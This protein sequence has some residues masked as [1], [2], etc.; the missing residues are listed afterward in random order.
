MYYKGV[1]EFLSDRAIVA[2]KG[3]VVQEAE[4]RS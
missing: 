4:L 2:T 1:Y 3:P